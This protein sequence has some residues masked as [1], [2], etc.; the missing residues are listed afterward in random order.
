MNVESGADAGTHCAGADKSTPYRRISQH[1]AR[2]YVRCRPET[3]EIEIIGRPDGWHQNVEHLASI[4][5]LK[6]PAKRLCIERHHS[7]YSRC[8]WHVRHDNEACDCSLIDGHVEVGDLGDAAIIGGEHQRIVWLGS[9]RTYLEPAT[10][11]QSGI[12]LGQR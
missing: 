2:E 7:R 8:G 10:D 5:G 6:Q 11:N 3:S 1:A 12:T 4:R 9:P